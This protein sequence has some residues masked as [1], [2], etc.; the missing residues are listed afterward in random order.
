MFNNGP[1]FIGL[2]VSSTLSTS[3]PTTG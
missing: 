1:V 2:Y 3:S